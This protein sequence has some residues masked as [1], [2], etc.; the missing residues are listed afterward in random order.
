MGCGT[1]QVSALP[2]VCGLP[3]YCIRGATLSVDQRLLLASSWVACMQGA[4]A[5]GG[6]NAE[7]SDDIAASSLSSL[8]VKQSITESP[9]VLFYD[10]F[11]GRLFEICPPSRAL[12]KSGLLVQGRKLVQMVNR[13][14]ILLDDPPK[15]ESELQ[16]LGERHVKY[17]AKVEH[18]GP[19]GEAL[20]FALEK[21]CGPEVWTPE[22]ARAWLLAYSVIVGVMIPAQILEAQRAAAL[23]KSASGSGY[24]S[25]VYVRD[26]DSHR[27]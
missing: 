5:C 16:A 21:C 10:A 2:D 20:L 7:P 24:F 11:Y 9:I 13:I 1:S 3:D 18:Y 4:Q 17:G 14:I 26:S 19:V 23:T 8:R 15:L 22:V 25:L 12:F 6:D 27:D